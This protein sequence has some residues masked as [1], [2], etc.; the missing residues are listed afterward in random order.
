MEISCQL[1]F[2]FSNK[3]QMKCLK[4][5]LGVYNLKM[6]NGSYTPGSYMSH[7]FRRKQRSNSRFQLKVSSSFLTLTSWFT[8]SESN[9]LVYKRHLGFLAQNFSRKV[10]LIHESLRYLIQGLKYL[11]NEKSSYEKIS[12]LKRPF[13][14]KKDGVFLFTISLLL[15]E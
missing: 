3:V 7:H 6:Q 9:G 15:P 2:S 14:A 1:E 12:L 4:E 10:R 5:L 13:K 11:W 8:A